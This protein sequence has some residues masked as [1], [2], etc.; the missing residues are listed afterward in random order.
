VPLWQKKAYFLSAPVSLE[1]KR[2]L[3]TGLV[4]CQGVTLKLGPTSVPF[5]R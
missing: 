2:G 5:F 3:D 1:V 4:S